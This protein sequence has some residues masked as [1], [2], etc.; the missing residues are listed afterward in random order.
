[1]SKNNL[2]D[3]LVLMLL[4]Y[5]VGVIR[6]LLLTSLGVPHPSDQ[7]SLYFHAVADGTGV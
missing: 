7:N 2:I 4:L 3:P 6:L 5:F 1:L